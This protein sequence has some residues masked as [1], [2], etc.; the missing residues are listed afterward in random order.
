MVPLLSTAKVKR[1]LLQSPLILANGSGIEEVWE[2]MGVSLRL[3][4]EIL[5]ESM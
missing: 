5:P 2:S 3:R 1:V 4:L